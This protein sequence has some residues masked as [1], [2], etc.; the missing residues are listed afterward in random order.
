[1]PVYA[2]PGRPTSGQPEHWPG[3]ARTPG[4]LP[5]RPPNAH[6]FPELAAERGWTRRR[7]PQHVA[8]ALSAY[9]RGISQ[10]RVQHRLR[11]GDALSAPHVARHDA[12]RRDP[13]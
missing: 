11:S 3:Y 5:V 2:S 6:A 9:A 1:M 4:G 8:A 10:A 13:A 7:D 12:E